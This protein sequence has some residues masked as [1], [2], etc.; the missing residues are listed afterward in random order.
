MSPIW[1]VQGLRTGPWWSSRFV[2]ELGIY[3]ILPPDLDCHL[4]RRWT[5][6]RDFIG[7]TIRLRVTCGSRI[8]VTGD[9]P[10]SDR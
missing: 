3:L 4:D 1:T 6:R 10:D 7:M 9:A 5:D 8:T 2:A